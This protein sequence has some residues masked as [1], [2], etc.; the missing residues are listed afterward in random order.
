[1]RKKWQKKT[2]RN[3]I[4]I[5]IVIVARH[6]GQMAF[7]ARQRGGKQQITLLNILFCICSK[8]DQ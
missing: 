5:Y 8:N 3:K 7:I 6:K 1:M 4:K 2:E